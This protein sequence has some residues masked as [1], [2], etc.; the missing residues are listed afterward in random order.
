MVH[1][2][3][4]SCFRL[5]TKH[6]LLRKS[7][8]NLSA[9]CT[10]GTYVNVLFKSDIFLEYTTTNGLCITKYFIQDQNVIRCEIMQC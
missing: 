6:D 5:N 3:E 1:S 8:F 9:Y 7:I 2:S 10:V 4:E